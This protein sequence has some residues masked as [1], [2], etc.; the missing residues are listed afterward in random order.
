MD[1]L[2]TA[3]CNPSLPFSDRLDAAR[4]CAIVCPDEVPHLGIANC[5]NGGLL[6]NENRLEGFFG[7]NRD[8]LRMKLTDWGFECDEAYDTAEEIQVS[9][10]ALADE[11][12]SWSRWTAS[13][14][15]ADWE[16]DVAQWDTILR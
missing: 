12:Q 11:S 9:F 2:F 10:P 1:N 13:R 4:V 15:T 3:A 7:D 6:I 5:S 16:S 14:R 8:S